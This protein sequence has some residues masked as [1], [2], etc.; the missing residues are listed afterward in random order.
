MSEDPDR[1]TPDEPSS[2]DTDGSTSDPEVIDSE[3][4]VTRLVDAGIIHE[5][6]KVDDLRLTDEFREDWWKRIEG[7][8]DEGRVRREMAVV[9]DIESAEVTLD[10]TGDGRLVVSH[11]ET[12]LGEWPSRAAFISDLALQPTIAAWLPLW[13]YLDPISR[14]ELLAR[15]RAFLE[16]CPSCEG[17][18]EIE[19]R[20]NAEIGQGSV[21]IA[22][23]NCGQVI[24][25][26]EL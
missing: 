25:S 24:V 10:E 4:L 26:S 8:H 18:L 7:F 16:T 3:G 2:A 13:E 17:A 20:A 11:G 6:E 9:A 22:C 12:E 5:D 23:V 21:S 15:I 14:G 1:P 19:E